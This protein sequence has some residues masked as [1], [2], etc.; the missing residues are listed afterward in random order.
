VNQPTSASDWQRRTLHLLALWAFAVAEPLYSVLRNNREFF[1]AHRSGPLDLFL[2]IVALSLALPLLLALLV[3]TIGHLWPPAGR[4]L[5]LAL[6]A[7]L[8]A[9]L[10]SQ[11]LARSANLTPVT[12][13]LL[14]GAAGVLVAGA[15]ARVAL[16]GTFLTASS[17]AVIVFPAIFLLHPSMRPFLHPTGA[18]AS[19]QASLR[20]T[21]PP[22][23][24]VVFDQLPLTSLMTDDGQLDLDRYPGFA[25]LA[26]ESTWYRNASSVAELTGW[27][28][29]PILT[30]LRPQPGT[31]PTASDYP[32]N[33][34]T[35]LSG[36]YRLEVEEPITGLCPYSLCPERDESSRTRLIRSALDASVVYL[37]L[38]LPQT[39]RSRLPP[40]TH[41]WK[42]FVRDQQWQQR[43]AHARDDDRRVPP[44]DFI[45]GV[46]ADDP[47]PTLYFLHA[48]LPHE[49]YLFLPTGQLFTEDGSLP[50]LDG[51]RWVDEEWPVVQ[52]YRR[53]LVQLA[54]VDTI[55]GQ[56]VTRLKSEGL[57]TRALVVLTADHG[58][59]F[60]PGRPFKG[61][62][63]DT[64][65]DIAPVP[66]FVKLPGQHNA[67]ISDRNVQSID[68]VP[69]IADAIDADLPWQPDGISAIGNIP[70]PVAKRIQH[71]SATRTM[72]VDAV[73][74]ARRRDDAARRK[75]R[76]FG[77][78][79]R[80]DIVP[81]AS[82]H[83]ELVGRR[84]SDLDTADANDVRVLVEEP[85]RFL[86]LDPAAR[87]VPSVLSGLVD[88]WRGHTR[89]ARLA[90][91]VNGVVRATTTTYQSRKGAWAAFVPP[92]AFRAG[93]NDLE[94]FV[95]DEPAG[96]LRR[97]Y[98][99]GDPP[100][101][102][103]LVSNSARD[104][105]AIAHKGFHDPEPG[106]D[107]YRWTN[108]DSAQVIVPPTDRP[109]PRSM[110]IGLRA[111]PPHGTPLRLT[112]N[113]CVV[114]D[115][116]LETGP[117]FRTFSLDGCHLTTARAGVR[118]GIASRSFTR[119]GGDDRTLGV[120]VA[121]LNL[122]DDPWPAAATS[123]GSSRATLKL[124]DAESPLSA[125][126][127]TVALENV[128]DT[129]W[130]GPEARGASG[131]ELTW[132]A[133]GHAPVLARAVV[134]LGHTFY[135]G[136]RERAMLPTVPA[137]RLP[138][139]AWDLTVQPLDGRGHPIP[140]EAACRV[141]VERAG[142]ATSRSR[143]LP[144]S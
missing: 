135:P 114:F 16:A 2:L 123:A 64:L 83:A 104:Y 63:E 14:A 101:M 112:V 132:R 103:N 47:Q 32:N 78:G 119:G 37:H 129:L 113:E 17:L 138:G 13:L 124:V 85:T 30:G 89:S 75:V 69:T 130:L 4:G 126:V 38:T 33:L 116:R 97:A 23:V 65:P 55:V 43:W 5:H 53:H 24:F 87:V 15:Y 39:L 11:V 31:L 82:T 74:F 48:L 3:A 127:M 50:G 117:W 134:P 141:R 79:S 108:G 27:A 60:R 19:R 41:D 1:V 72:E 115:G 57:W 120:A 77:T 49:P 26:R 51:E 12:H 20:G 93:R 139:D 21:R 102:L 136:D 84:V 81:V 133:A 7:T 137:Q 35:M 71:E 56:L 70:P 6:V 128:G 100:K 73:E 45:A 25:A 76:W 54:Y 88:D 92:H 95:I 118:V 18:G 66:L 109:P 107:W 22:I 40:L 52:A 59:S 143:R 98:A 125:P 106:P 91:A 10:A 111:V 144:G 80:D 142:R 42:S 86:R 36:G 44:R 8:A 110:R 67:A 105:W 99:L 46:S 29:P 96:R 90:I 131:L 28:M 68:I 34:F 9:A 62:E 61:L 122:L 94:V 58:V 140:T 121:T